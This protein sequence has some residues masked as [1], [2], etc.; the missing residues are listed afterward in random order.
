MTVAASARTPE[1]L[2]REELLAELRSSLASARSARGRLVLVGGEAGVGK[3]A[4]ARRFCDELRGTF[5]V[6]WGGCDP[7][8]TPRPLGPFLEMAA[9]APGKVADAVAATAGAYEVAAALLATGDQRQP[10]VLVLEDLHWA[11]EATLDVLR[12]LARK[13]EWAPMLVVATYRHDLDRSHPL[14]IALG[15]IATRPAVE[16]LS[17]APLSQSAV[18]T[19]AG[20]AVDAEA[21]YRKTSGNPFFVTEI[22]ATGDGL[23]PESVVD[24]VLARTARLSPGARAV[25]DAVA[26]VPPRADLWLL[27][28]L[29]DED[30]DGLD[31]CVAAGILTYERDGVEFRH[32]LARLA[33]EASVEPRRRIALHRRALAALRSPPGGDLDL[34]RLA[35]HAETARDADAVLEFAP[36]AG[37]R[38]SSL[39]AHREAAS[40]YEAALRHADALE[41]SSKA[42]ILRRFSRECYLTDRADDAVRALESAVK[43]YRRLGDTLREGDTM[44]SL[45]NILWCPGRSDE[46]RARGLAAVA[47][48]ETQPPGP[49]LAGAYLVLSFLYQTSG[50]LDEAAVW[51]GKAVDLAVELRDMNALCGALLRTGQL[52]G[53]SDLERGTRTLER[54]LEIAEHEDIGE[55]VA[56]C[57]TA[58]GSIAAEHR[59]YDQAR[60]HFAV[61]IDYCARHGNDLTL[62]YNL[63]YDAQAE[64]HQGRWDEAADSAAQVLR[65]RAVST[66]PRTVALVVLALVRARRGDPDA[67]PLLDEALGLA[68]LPGELPRIGLVASARAEAA[69][70]AGRSDQIP[71]L[72]AVAFELALA[73]DARRTIGVLGRWRRRAGLVDAVPDGLPEPETLELAG[74]WPAAA[75][76]WDRVGCPYEAAI[77]R[78][79]SDDDGALRTAYAALQLLGA[80]PATRMVARR[81][82][83]RGARGITRGPRPTT[84]AHPANLTLRECEVLPLVAAGLRDREIAE[85][86]FLSTRTVEHHVSAILRKL[87]V[88]TRGEAVAAAGRLQLLRDQ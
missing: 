27:D 67:E 32:E 24:A 64:L 30:I 62:L 60:R 43:C 39:G 52:E 59:A 33:V 23:I 25:I 70:L 56:D 36:A 17:V 40:L 38:A 35:H 37:D 69:W 71:A 31:E 78:A 80:R 74:D 57:V 48:L 49:E 21:L 85:R 87:D 47:L 41:S 88:R 77:A 61:G 19:L 42:E 53:V 46:A 18:A 11:D 83:E 55:R 73:L 10:L 72:T 75:A 65:T 14:R 76:A 66:Y 86:L 82:R 20:P 84:R 51:S 54:A 13:V 81:M 2:E 50:E 28:A 4:L 68:E 6:L 26:V 34:A 63:A 3:T 7:L 79:A 45:A 12:L 1:L 58:L 16:R 15:E 8:V 44:R 5:N 29:A 9:E 22:L